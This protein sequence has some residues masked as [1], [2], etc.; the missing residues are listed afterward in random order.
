M[1]DS[2]RSSFRIGVDLEQSKHVV[3]VDYV[4]LAELDRIFVVAE[5]VVAIGQTET[6]LVH[7]CN[8]L[9]SVLIILIG[10]ETKQR[11]LTARISETRKY[12]SLNKKIEHAVKMTQFCGKIGSTGDRR[13]TLQI[14]RHAQANCETRSLRA[15][16]CLTEVQSLTKS[17]NK[18]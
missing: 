14:I 16:W 9:G 10:K 13:K 8:Y 2:P 6:A 17:I 3:Y 5:I 15:L 18:L 12:G 4:F 7:E 1:H 11:F